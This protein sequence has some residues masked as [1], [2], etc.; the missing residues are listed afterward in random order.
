[1][2]YRRRVVL[3]RELYTDKI[4]KELEFNLKLTLF[5]TVYEPFTGRYELYFTSK[6]KN[7]PELNT[8]PVST[9]FIKYID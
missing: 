3:T 8:I 6:C 1:M 4:I 5:K 2:E 9:E 7:E